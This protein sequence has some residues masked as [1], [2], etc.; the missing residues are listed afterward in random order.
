MFTYWKMSV[1]P[2]LAYLLPVDVLSL[3]YLCLHLVTSELLHVY[4]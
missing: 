3:S 1:M 2:V 4:L